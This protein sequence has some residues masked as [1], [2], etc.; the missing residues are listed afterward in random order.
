MEGRTVKQIEQ[1]TIDELQQALRDNIESQRQCYRAG[2]PRQAES[3]VLRT[4][5]RS[6]RCELANRGEC[7]GWSASCGVLCAC[8]DVRADNWDRL[9]AEG[10]SAFDAGCLTA[11]CQRHPA[12]EAAKIAARAMRERGEKYEIHKLIAEQNK[13][14]S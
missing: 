9:K 11:Y 4:D 14:E 6:I 8:A 5:E 3:L 10:W 13:C 7:C 12:V 1:M 2:K